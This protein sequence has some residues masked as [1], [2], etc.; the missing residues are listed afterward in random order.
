MQQKRFI[1]LVPDP[2]GAQR[3]G[4]P[5]IDIQHHQGEH[6]YWPQRLQRSKYPKFKKQEKSN[7]IVIVN[8]AIACRNVTR[9]GEISHLWQK[10]KKNG[11]IFK[12]YL[13]MRQVFNSL[14]HDLYTF[15]PT[16]YWKHNMV[17][18]PITLKK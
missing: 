17:T 4:V 8:K 5:R 18:W 2:H 6:W 3:P 14:W 7:L 11:D 15:W 10:F 1:V 12:V 9:F 16:K 13:V